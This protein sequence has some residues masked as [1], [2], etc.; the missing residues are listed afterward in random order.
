ML[1]EFSLDSSAWGI[2]HGRLAAF[3]LSPALN[4]AWVNIGFFLMARLPHIFDYYLP[5]LKTRRCFPLRRRNMGRTLVAIF[6]VD[7]GYGY[8]HRVKLSFIFV[9][10]SY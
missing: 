5:Y 6:L 2:T 8:K 10:L 1:V 9:W 7:F 3:R 4:L